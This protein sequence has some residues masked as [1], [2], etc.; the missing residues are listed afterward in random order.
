MRLQ[1]E[2]D[3]DV[4]T[5]D[6]WSRMAKRFPP[7]SGKRAGI[8]SAGGRAG[9]AHRGGAQGSPL[10]IGDRFIL[11]GVPGAAPPLGPGSHESLD[12]LPRCRPRL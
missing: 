4:P 11:P 10:F 8:A 6:G 5:T 3:P 7:G 2:T 1:S 12:T 9:T